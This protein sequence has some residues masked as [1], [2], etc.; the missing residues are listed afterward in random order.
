MKTF[1]NHGGILPGTSTRREVLRAASALALGSGCAGWSLADTKATGGAWP[2][3]PVRLVIAGP[4]GGSPD[5]VA[6]ALSDQL[7]RSTK[8]AFIVDPKPGGAGVIALNELLQAPVDSYTL[9]VGVSSLVSEIPH[10][11]KMRHDTRKAIVPLAELARGGIVLVAAP[12]LPVKNLKDVIELSR[13]SK[14]GLSYASY[15]PGTM[16]HVAGLIMGQT[17]GARLTHVAY[18]GST[19]GLN[20]LMGGH[21]PLMFDG[22][23]TSLPFIRSGKIKAIAITS[24]QRSPLLPEVPTFQEQGLPQLTYTGWLGLWAN[25]ALPADKQQAIRQTV[26]QAMDT[27]E[28]KSTLAGAGFEPGTHRDSAMLR[29]ELLSDY[30]RVGKVLQGTNLRP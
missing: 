26:L 11:V 16:S 25:S 24:P 2:D 22:L 23:A 29:A 3:K 7:G 8:Q 6:R 13:A 18:K 19:A 17:T 14:D 5:M 28:F 4:A 27:P 20:D 21:I 12:E 9:L 10:I 15:S 30:D 1:H